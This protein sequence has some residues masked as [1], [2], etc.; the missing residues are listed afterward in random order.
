[1]SSPEDFANWVDVT[2][3]FAKLYEYIPW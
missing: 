3:M 1:M 2:H